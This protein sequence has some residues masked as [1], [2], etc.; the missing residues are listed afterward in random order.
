[1]RSMTINETIE[2]NGGKTE[3]LYCPYCSKGFPYSYWEG[4][5][6][7]YNRGKAAIALRQHIYECCLN[8]C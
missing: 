5:T 4:F 3:T 8:H 2:A 6:Y 1:M 7:A